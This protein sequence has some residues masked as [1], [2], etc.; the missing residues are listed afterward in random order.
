MRAKAA[1]GYVACGAADIGDA[2]KVG[3]K[4][5]N[6]AR[7]ASLGLRVP[8]WYVVTTRAFDDAVCGADASDAAALAMPAAVACEIR[9]AHG[10]LFAEGTLV[11]VRS[12]AACEDGA[13]A[14]FAGIHESFLYVRGIEDVLDAVRKVWAS[15][16]D[17]GAVAYRS[18]A[19]L[20]PERASM[21]VVVQAMVDPDVSGVAFTANPADGDVHRVVVSSLYGV[22]EGLVGEG[23]DADTYVVSKSTRDVERTIGRKEW[24]LVLDAVRGSGLARVPV[25]ERRRDASSLDGA[26]LR[27]TVEAALRIE[28]AYGR[29][30]DIEFAYAGSELV[31]LQSRP[32]TTLEEYGPAA[33][34]RQIWDNSNIAESYGGVTTPMT[35]SFI[36]RAY[37]IVYESFSRVMGIDP[38]VVRDNADV[39]ENMLGLFKGRVYYNLASWYRVVQ[40]FPG[41]EY[42]KTF[43]ESMMGLGEAG[44][45]GVEE[46]RA[47]WARRYFVELP[48]LVKLLARSVRNF[49]RIQKLVDA[50]MAGFDASYA[51]W[52]RTDFAGKRPHGLL[53]IYRQME[54]EFLFKWEAPIINDFY[55]MVFSGALGRLCSSWCGDETGSL[56]SRLL[57]ARGRIE[58]LEP[59]RRIVDL[60]RIASED[61]ALT[62]LFEESSP[63]ELAR[64]LPGDERYA[65]FNAAMAT[66]L[67]DFGCR[68]P[69]ELKLEEPSLSERPALAYKAVRELVLRRA[70][71]RTGPAGG[72]ADALEEAEAAISSNGGGWMRRAIFRRVLARA[73]SGVANRERMRLARGRVYGLVRRLLLSI[74]NTFAT[75]GVLEAA[76]DVFYLTLDETWDYIKGT[77]VTGYPKPLVALRR[78]EYRSYREDEAGA[79]DDRFETYGVAYHRNALR[80]HT[81]ATPP[82][83]DDALRG[84]PCSAGR[85]RAPVVVVNDPATAPDVAGKIIVARRTDPGWVMLYPSA[86]GIVVERGSILSHAAVVAREMGLPA[87][88]GVAGLVSTVATGDVIEL[89]GDTGHVNVIPDEMHSLAAE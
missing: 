40:M 18:R 83:G 37:G 39:F 17:G 52:S 75:E 28:A 88:V 68:C 9:A 60:A 36:K 12:S 56:V 24:A 69:N 71:T 4:G 89:D 35:F 50:F 6:L 64:E 74:G 65:A 67:D 86:V 5:A 62:T 87:V 32:I 34:N 26:R 44:E 58:S 84:I 25:D 15:A 63:A 10:R 16:L 43:M 48:K 72:V 33:G 59:A 20:S 79:P 47:G 76:D 82:A 49:A 46:V 21:A 66:Y 85:V 55:V 38:A 54:A 51:K 8:T 73:R 19:G 13:A 27:E 30:Q 22:G 45:G 2:A 1:N 57:S 14:S 29:P 31:I 53:E 42:N 70:A 7:L 11:A 41:Y 23:L 78:E 77:S 61:A 80:R 3:G 81:A